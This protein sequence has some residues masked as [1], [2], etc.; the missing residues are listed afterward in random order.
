MGLTL[1]AVLTV[2]GAGFA[3]STFL[4]RIQRGVIRKI[5]AVMA[6]LDIPVQLV[7]GQCCS[8]HTDILRGSLLTVIQAIARPD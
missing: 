6:L 7:T 5:L 4:I 8:V 1:V 2:T 3:I